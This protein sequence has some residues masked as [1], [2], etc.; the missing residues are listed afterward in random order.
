MVLLAGHVG[1]SSNGEIKKLVHNSKKK[2]KKSLQF[3]R[4]D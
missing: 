1:Q 2:R 3:G 4:H